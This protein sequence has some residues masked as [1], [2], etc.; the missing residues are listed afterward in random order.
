MKKY[1]IY[2]AISLLIITLLSCTKKDEQLFDGQP[3]DR[4]AAR[5]TE[6]LNLLTSEEQGYKATYFS[7]DD[8]F[9]GYTFYMKFSE[10]G[11]VEMT[12]DFDADTNL[13]T[14]SYKVSYGTTTELVFTTR[15]HIHKVSDPQV[16]GLTGT[17][18]KGTSVFQYFSNKDGIISFKDIRNENTSTLNLEAT[19]FT[20]FEKE[21]VA[22]VKLDLSQSSN[23]DPLPTSPVF[24]VLKIESSEGVS[25]FNFNYDPLR[26]FATPRITLDDGS[27]TELKFGV[28]FE[29]GKL[30]ASPALEFEGVTYKEFE[31]NLVNRSYVSTVNG[32]T[33]T[34]LFDNE[35]AFISNDIKQI[36]ETG[37]N[38]FLYRISLGVNSLTSSAHD[39]MLADV[40]LGLNKQGFELTEYT[41]VTDF[42][43]EGDCSTTLGIR[44]ELLSDRTKAYSGSF[45]FK[46]ARVEDRK[47]FLEYTGPNGGNGEFFEDSAK[48]LIDFF[49]SS[50]GMIYTKEG[51]F[52][53]SVASY[54]NRAS[55]FTSIENPS[56]RVYGL[57][58]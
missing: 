42:D 26:S 32:T 37:V 47:L 31:Y 25:K 17:G 30:I 2:Y 46:K 8:E 52:S 36:S 27:V 18:F 1:K 55:T 28:L 6:L 57:L 41:L 7:K 3:A 43:T 40:N 10:D 20:D 56:I 5:N 16:S 23:L 49:N 9:G 14:S 15:N 44:V 50:K 4:I 39:K 21:S 24:Q 48:P 38:T 45:C 29:N 51:S 12:S 11:T 35:P 54:T 33:A 34:I 53:S 58:F 22:A 19:G 13:E